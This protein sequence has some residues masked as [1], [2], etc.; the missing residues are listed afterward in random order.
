[1]IEVSVK[2]PLDNILKY[3]NYR[4]KNCGSEVF[5][6]AF[7]LKKIPETVLGQNTISPI[8]IFICRK[9]KTPTDDG[10]KLLNYEEDTITKS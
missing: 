5:I 4:C 2:H 8:N 9:C 7:I 3:K 6:S 10:L 1:M